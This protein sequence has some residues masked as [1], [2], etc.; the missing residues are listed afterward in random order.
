MAE[1]LENKLKIYYHYAI[2]PLQVKELEEG[3]SRWWLTTEN[4]KID[5]AYFG[6]PLPNHNY[7]LG[8]NIEFSRYNSVLELTNYTL[9]YTNL[10]DIE[11]LFNDLEIFRLEKLIGK[12]VSIYLMGPQ[13]VGISAYREIK[14]ISKPTPNI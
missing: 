3:P 11:R 10:K 12:E 14:N 6:K 4:V 7:P 1:T 8:L 5:K 13:V 2:T 9:T